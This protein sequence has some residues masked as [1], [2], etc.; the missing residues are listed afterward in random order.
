MNYNRSVLVRY[1]NALY[2]I[3]IAITI[4]WAIGG[5]VAALLAMIFSGAGS[6]ETFVIGLLGLAA[7][8]GIGW[9]M[10]FMLRVT[11]QLVLCQVE[12]ESHLQ[13]IKNSAIAGMRSGQFD[14]PSTPD[15]LTNQ[16][17]GK[18]RDTYRPAADNTRARNQ[19][20]LTANAS[21][22]AQT[23]TE[24]A[25][26]PETPV[27][28]LPRH[29][30]E[31]SLLPS[32]QEIVDKAFLPQHVD[33]CHQILDRAENELSQRFPGE[34]PSTQWLDFLD[35]VAQKGRKVASYSQ[36]AINEGSCIGCRGRLSMY[37]TGEHM[38][39][40]CKSKAADFDKLLTHVH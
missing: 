36:K 13:H 25:P 1:A 7:G 21:A 18:Q 34:T 19:T 22:M 31:A 29:K 32:L 28:V 20:E 35:D 39:T 15:S 3:A 9:L 27:V 4:F 16:E 38:C 37:E 23:S 11:A 33:R 10:G 26:K 8:A 6:L 24:V 17:T 40:R 12:Q 14:S 30:S 5:F 2:G